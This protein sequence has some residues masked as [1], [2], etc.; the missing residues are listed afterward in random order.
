MQPLEA[1]S[2]IVEPGCGMSVAT[3]AHVLGVS[4]R[5]VYRLCEDGELG[6]TRVR[7]RR[8]TITPEQIEQYRRRERDSNHQW[9]Q[10][11]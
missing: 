1:M 9:E 7:R 5:T 3:A 4:I 11:Q 10:L 2:T 8:I 6:H